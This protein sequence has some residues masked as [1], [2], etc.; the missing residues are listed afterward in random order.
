MTAPSRTTPPEQQSGNSS[1]V[2]VPHPPRGHHGDFREVL[3]VADV[4]ERIM[5][6]LATQELAA[7]GM[8]GDDASSLAAPPAGWLTVT[9][10]RLPFSPAS[11]VPYRTRS[12]R[13]GSGFPSA[14]TSP[15]AVSRYCTI[16]CRTRT[17]RRRFSIPYS[18]ATATCR[19][20]SSSG[21]GRSSTV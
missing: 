18:S 16:A 10:E 13:G 3:A 11:A 20:S 12:S 8:T 21:C 5:D 17:F 9:T 1:A 14:G 4:G 2:K 6:S 15:S 19:S 7:L